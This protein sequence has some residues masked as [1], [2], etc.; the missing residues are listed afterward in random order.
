[1]TTLVPKF[2]VKDGALVPAGAINRS[3]FDKLLDVISVKDFGAKGDGTTDDAAAINAAYAALISGSASGSG[4]LYFPTGTYKINSKLDFTLGN[5]TTTLNIYGDGNSASVIVPNF[6]SGNAIEVIDTP[7]FNMMDMGVSQLSISRDASSFLVYVSDCVIASINNIAA[8]CF[9]GGLFSIN[10]TTFLTMS[11]CQG[12]S[13]D[14]TGGNNCLYFAGTSGAHIS[15]CQFRVGPFGTGGYT[16]SKPCVL[17][18]GQSTS[19]NITNSNFVGGGPLSVFNIS[20]ITSTSTTFTLTT[21]VNHNFQAGDFLVI[22]NS[23]VATYNSTWRI[24]S[25]TLN[26]ITVTTALNPGTAT[27]VGTAESQSACVL[28]TNAKGAVN[29]SRISNCLFESGQQ[30]AYGRVGLYI[31]G[32]KGVAPIQGWTITGCYADYGS[33]G[34]LLSGQA[35]FAASQTTVFGFTIGDC[36]LQG[37]NRG[38]QLDQCAGVA[39]SNC[40]GGEYLFTQA[41]NLGYPGYNEAILIYSAPTAPFTQGISITNCVMGMGRGFSG[42]NY[43]YSHGI[44]LDGNTVQ[45]LTITGNTLYGSR[46]AIAD[47]FA[48]YGVGYPNAIWKIENNLL[49]EGAWPVTT[50]SQ[51]IP[52]CTNVGTLLILPPYSDTSR[53]TGVASVAS[54]TPGWINNK[55]TL[56]FDTACTLQTGGNIAI[57]ATYNVL[58]GQCLTIVFDGTNWYVK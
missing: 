32:R 49:E 17:I 18:E 4:S 54:I 25:V 38:L 44:L 28:V 10:S 55:K 12:D 46:F 39:V 23:D 57:T 21:S 43:G 1:M 20:G 24:T 5:A 42:V 56:I 48:L 51:I 40:I 2:D 9:L 45:S 27:A 16:N 30:Y 35:S 47:T 34:I 29:E 11:N 52:S 7:V 53:V 37:L 6:V 14:G 36:V 19:I 58:V 22:R 3:Y 31:D 26:T 41:D 13:N 33:T 8:N 15:N 50:S